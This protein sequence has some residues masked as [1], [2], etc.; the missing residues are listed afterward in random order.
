MKPAVIS[1][2]VTLALMASGCSGNQGPQTQMHTQCRNT[3]TDRAFYGKA[4]LHHDQARACDGIAWSVAGPWQLRI[5]PP[6][7]TS[8][9]IA[10]VSLR[11]DSLEPIDGVE[12]YP[13][14]R[15][16]IAAYFAPPDGIDKARLNSLAAKQA[17]STPE[18]LYGFEM[19]RG[20]EYAGNKVPVVLW[21]EGGDFAECILSTTGSVSAIDDF[22]SANSLVGGV[23]VVRYPLSRDLLRTGHIRDKRVLN[24]IDALVV[25]P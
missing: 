20:R 21:G 7:S 18:S 19:L 13:S 5:S 3:V 17:V 24:A 25:E 9:Q 11:T 12:T 6:N 8:L 15:M 4:P 22:C 14:E 10:N 1:A 2:I 23:L 16:D